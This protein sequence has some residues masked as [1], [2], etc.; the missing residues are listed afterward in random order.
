[1]YN[2][3]TPGLCQITARPGRIGTLDSLDNLQS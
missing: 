2:A 1:M 3:R